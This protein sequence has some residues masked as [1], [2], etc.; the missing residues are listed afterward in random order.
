M[1]LN[2]RTLTADEIEIRVGAIDNKA[3]KW[4]T[5]L[6]YKNARVD[7]DLL[8][9]TV[10]PMNWKRH[11]LRD[12]ANCIVSI[13]DEEKK[14]WVSK[15]DT[16]TE[17]NTAQKK[18]QAS[19]SFKRACVNWGIGRELYT[20][21]KIFVNGDAKELKKGT[22]T[23]K[24]ISYNEK[25]GIK[26]LVIVDK[27]DRVVFQTDNKEYDK[28]GTTYDKATTKKE[29]TKPNTTKKTSKASITDAQVKT[30]QILL[31]EQPEG[32]KEKIYEKLKIKSCKELS[33]ANADKLIK[34]LRNRK[35]E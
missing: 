25:R 21:P 1:K 4:I 11:H 17:S 19:D 30:L 12:N 9:E 6:L 27:Y 7:M 15:E 29:T 28:V 13:W 20:S 24:S 35:G 18:G 14:E 5:L 3:C 10:G 8:D 26:E 33:S 16:G 2:F 32:T 22:Y 34:Q 31:K 23:V